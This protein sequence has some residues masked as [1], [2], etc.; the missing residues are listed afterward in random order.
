MDRVL[1]AARASGSLNLSNRSLKEVPYEVY[2]SLDAVGEGEKWWEAVELQKLI[3]AHNDIESL[4]EDL[5]NLPLLSVLNVSHNKLSHLPAAI[6]EFDCSNNQLKDLPGS[7]GR[8]LNLSEL[9]LHHRHDTQSFI[10]RQSLS[11]QSLAGEDDATLPPSRTSTSTSL[12]A[13]RYMGK[14]MNSEY[15][16]TNSF[17]LLSSR[18]SPASSLRCNLISVPRPSGSFHLACIHCITPIYSLRLSMLS[19]VWYVPVLFALTHGYD[20]MCTHLV[21]RVTA[22]YPWKYLGA[23]G[24]SGAFAISEDTWN[25]PLGRGTEIRLHLREEAGEYLEE[26]KLKEL[27][28]RYSEFIN[29]PIYLWATK[30]VD[31]EASNNC[32]TSLPEELVNCS[33]LSKLDVEGNKLTVLSES[34][35]ASCIMLTELNASK[36][37]LSGM[38]QSIGSLSRLIRL[39]LHQNR[40]SSIP[41]SIMGCSSLVEFYMGNNLLSSLPAEI[42]ALPRLGTFDLHSNQL[43]EYPV[44]A[45]KLRLS[46][47][48]LSNNSLSGLPSEIGMMT[49][50]RKLLLMGNPMRS[51]RSTLVNGPTPALLRYLR[52]R[53]PA[54]EESAA[55]TPTKDNVVS[56]AARMSITS[57]E[58]SLGGLGLSAVPS[59]VCE[60][61]EVTKVDLSKNS[62]EELPAELSSCVSLEALILSRNK[63]KEWPGAILKSLSN[64]SCLKLDNNPLLQVNEI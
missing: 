53:L 50:L 5:R 28:K 7:L 51:L 2:K 18:Y 17:S 44:E 25:E 33:K 19:L 29:F 24:A 37:L 38:P 52:S 3:L 27:V 43:K 23:C 62:I 1:K 41:S 47:L 61:R 40:I 55:S 45:C 35:F 64:L 31:V 6:G 13:Q 57:K 42:G 48:D 22:P 12:V 4:R 39:D 49:T 26:S 36:N 46:V 20:I 56:M 8:C 15:L 10:H 54:D 60:S 34:I 21:L 16:F 63:I 14:L 58:L 30:E 9:K 32:I 11:T 59:E